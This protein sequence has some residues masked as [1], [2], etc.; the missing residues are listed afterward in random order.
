MKKVDPLVL[1]FA[2][3]Q[4][5]DLKAINEFLTE[6]SFFGKSVVPNT[7][8]VK[9]YNTLA[10]CAH[11]YAQYPALVRWM[12]AMMALT[13]EEIHAA[14]AAEKSVFEAEK[15]VEAEAEEEDDDS[16][17]DLFG[18]DS[19]DSEAERLF[20]ERAKAAQARIDARNAAKGKDS[21]AKSMII[22]KIA[23]YEA[24]CDLNVLV[25]QIKEK[26]TKE[27]CVWGEYKLEDVAF[28]VKN[29]VLPATIVDDLVGTDELCEEIESAFEDDVQS[30][31]VIAFNKL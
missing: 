17:M 26:I 1:A 3:M 14:P 24:D 4:L 13:M 16:D 12:K 5:T 22:L 6:N 19:E 10:R 8:D 11:E 20:E 30:A 7:D 29:I 2:P 21:V 31:T 18:S 27:G 23:P 15:K 9:L 25:E 28:G